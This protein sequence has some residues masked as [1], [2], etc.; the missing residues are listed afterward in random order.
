MAGTCQDAVFFAANEWRCLSDMGVE[1][2]RKGEAGG[3]V[4]IPNCRLY[5]DTGGKECAQQA[6]L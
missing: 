2:R 6:Y 3:K 1:K 5:S 4:G